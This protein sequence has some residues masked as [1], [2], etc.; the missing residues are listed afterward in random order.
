M[1]ARRNR[2][3]GAALAGRPREPHAF[4]GSLDHDSP[5]SPDGIRIDALVSALRLRF[6]GLSPA[7]PYPANRPTSPRTTLMVPGRNAGPRELGGPAV[8]SQPSCRTA[9]YVVSLYVR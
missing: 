3:R 1:R 8:L 2:L 6:A 4:V 5:D 9:D 7:S